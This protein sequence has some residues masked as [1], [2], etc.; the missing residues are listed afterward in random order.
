MF[1]SFGVIVLNKERID[2]Y[3]ECWGKAIEAPTEYVDIVKELIVNLLE[4]YSKSFNEISVLNDDYDKYVIKPNN[5]KYSLE[6][7]FLNRLLR[8]VWEVNNNSSSKGT[9]MPSCMEIS[10][11][12]EK[13]K[14]Q[15]SRH[16][17]ASRDDF[18][19]LDDIAKKKVIMHEFEHALQTRFE[20]GALDLRY[21][22]A[23]KKIIEEI[24]KCKNG[25]YK[26]EINSYE[27]LV[28]KNPYGDYEEYISCGLH[29]SGKAKI[30]KTYRSVK[31]Y[32]NVTEIFNESESLEMSNAKIQEYKI[33]DKK[34]YL[35]VRNLESSNAFI[36]NYGYLLKSL[37][38]PRTTFIGM[39]FEPDILFET[40]NKRYGDVFSNYFQNDK[41]AYE[42]IILM[43]DKIKEK[44]AFD[45]HLFFQK[46][47][48]EC[49]NKKI[50]YNL[51]TS[52]FETL[53]SD[54]NTFKDNCIWANTSEARESLAHFRILK[55]I[56]NNIE[57]KKN[58]K[59]L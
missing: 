45:D 24:C 34:F 33:Y 31:G 44:D 54:V 18:L 9:Y 16:I 26:N 59:K 6:D 20:K 19:L 14:S 57:N 15:L 47:L 51:E 25:K 49:L 13:I 7:F 35:R 42:N 28:S 58:N 32:D 5:G 55:N 22:S 41:D 38:G 23:Y 52:S 4:E 39:Y 56:K 30:K 36:T 46:V 17:D 2:D 12:K 29:Y 48:S 50:N 53:M 27:S 21:R 1:F 10:F 37:I 3:I 43:L 40:F 8:N 11:N